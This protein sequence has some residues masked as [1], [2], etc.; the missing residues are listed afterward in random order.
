MR[1]Q[2]KVFG[3]IIRHCGC[4]KQQNHSQFQLFSKFTSDPIFFVYRNCYNNPGRLTW[5]L[6]QDQ[7]FQTETSIGALLSAITHPQSLVHALLELDAIT[8]FRPFERVA[9]MQG[10]PPSCLRYV[11]PL[12][13]LCCLQNKP[14]RLIDGFIRRKCPHQIRF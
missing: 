12:R 14:Q 9:P 6:G 2:T 8:C 11:R 7:G 13:N 10:E 4:S 3:R 5:L 1:L